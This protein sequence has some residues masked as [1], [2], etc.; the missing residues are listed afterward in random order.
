MTPPT[1]IMDTTG[2][3]PCGKRWW[4]V[5]R[6]KALSLRQ[7]FRCVISKMGRIWSGFSTNSWITAAWS[8]L[9]IIFSTIWEPMS[10]RS[11][12]STMRLASL[13]GKRQKGKSNI[14]ECLSMI[15]RNFWTRFSERT[16]ICLIL[17]SC[18]STIWTGNSRMCSPVAAWKWQISMGNRCL[19]WNRVRAVRW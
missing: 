8:I 17:S 4:N 9:T 10:M 6:E 18:R 5:I 3:K 11:A 2:R 12:G 1:H 16:G 15:C 14:W 13:P 7:N 19:S